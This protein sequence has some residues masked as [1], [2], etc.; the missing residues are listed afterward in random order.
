MK[1]RRQF[2]WEQK[3]DAY[4]ASVTANPFDWKVWR[5]CD[6]ACGAVGVM[7]GEKPKTP[8][9][10]TREPDAL[11]YMLHSG[12][13]GTIRAVDEAL[14]PFDLADHPKGGEDGDVIFFFT[15]R[16]RQG[17]GLF[18]KGRVLGPGPSGL[19]WIDP[20][21]VRRTWRIL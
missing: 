10:P 5:C 13:S 21:L 15:T 1:I 6:F 20:A 2:D 12:A 3:L 11:R 4:V 18:F 7:T 9:I 19:Y 16:L 8:P 17:L 14:S